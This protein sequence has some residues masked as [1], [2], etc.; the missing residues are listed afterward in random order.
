MDSLLTKSFGI[1]L[2][3]LLTLVLAAAFPSPASIGL[4]IV[5][6]SALVGY[7][8]IIILKDEEKV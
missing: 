8:T 6:G 3:L 1:F 4:L 5:A 7:Q 2:G